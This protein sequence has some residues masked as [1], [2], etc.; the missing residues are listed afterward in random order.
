MREHT[1]DY[2]VTALRAQIDKQTLT[3]YLITGPR[4]SGKTTLMRLL[5]VTIREDAVLSQAWLPVRFPEELPNV[6]SLR[7]LLAAALE[8]LADQGIFGA[9]TWHERVEAEMDDGASQDLAIS[10]LRQIAGEQ[11]KRLVL[12]IENL[13]A[14]FERGLTDTT[15]ATLRRLLMTDPFMM[16]VASAVQVFPAIR[17]YDEA[18]FNYFCPVALE[19]L[20]EEQASEILK[21]RAAWDGN[22]RFDS[23]YRKHRS[24]VRAISL[25]TGGNPRLLLMLYEVLTLQD[26]G[27]AVQ[28]LRVLVDELTPLLKDIVE[29]QLTKQQ[30]TILDALMRLDGKAKPSQLAQKS[31]LPLNVV[32]M[33]LK[34]LTEADV[35]ELQGGGKGRPAWYTVRD[36]LFYTWYQMRYLRPQRRRIEMFVKVL[37]LWYEAE[38]RLEALHALSATLPVAQRTERD[39]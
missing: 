33:Q 28:A 4:G 20:N 36:R 29:H 6:T 2:L 7:D 34:R 39:Q 37:E 3:S 26:V 19:R 18:F 1:L 30:V 5:S 31:R 38:E 25:L 32:T 10:A 9:Q 14:L 16:I 8:V 17:A 24:K 35:L 23:Q 12:M 13:D 27:S 15:R 21:R 11:G 22:D